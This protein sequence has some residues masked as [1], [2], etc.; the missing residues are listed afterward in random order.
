VHATPSGHRFDAIDVRRTVR[1]AVDLLDEFDPRHHPHLVERRAHLAALVAGIDADRQ[2]V[3]EVVAVLDAVWSQLWGA[4]DDLVAA[5]ALPSTA[6]GAIHALHLGTG[7]VPKP[8]VHAVS[9]DLGGVV[10]DRQATRNHHGA[11]FQ[12]VCLWALEVIESLAA[13]GH[14]I[15]PGSAG[16]NV[17]VSGIAWA[18]VTP[19]VR[20]LIGDVLCEVSSIA[21]PCRQNARWFSDRRFDRIHHRHGPVSRMYATV[22][23][24]GTAAV[25]DAVVLEP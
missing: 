14:P 19:G 4:R 2:P 25:G 10:G 15:A 7:G 11:P 21:V 20:L 18:D 23:R 3:S 6:T 17:T 8:A 12:A 1:H 13:E 9:I 22:L 24:P 5:G 16:E